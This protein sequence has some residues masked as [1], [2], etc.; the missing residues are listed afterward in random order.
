MSEFVKIDVALNGLP[1]VGAAQTLGLEEWVTGLRATAEKTDGEV[2]YAFRWG[3]PLLNPWFLDLLWQMRIPWSVRTMLPVRGFQILRGN[4]LLRELCQGVECLY[5]PPYVSRLDWAVGATEFARRAVQLERKRYPVSLLALDEA[6][7][8]RVVS[9]FARFR[10]GRAR[11]LP[12]VQSVD[13]RAFTYVPLEYG[14]KGT[15]KCRDLPWLIGP[16]G[17]FMPC[18]SCAV[19]KYDRVWRSGRLGDRWP[20]EMRGQM[21]TC[22][23]KECFYDDWERVHSQQDRPSAE[24]SE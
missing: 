3:E 5:V 14:R 24:A 21:V 13:H 16:S 11:N 18:F 12:I 22:R 17:D 23:A 2:E 15:H 4:P 8:G 7:I 1:F 20:P 10:S 9:E 19:S 6:E